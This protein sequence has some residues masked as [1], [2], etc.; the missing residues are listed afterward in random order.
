MAGPGAGNSLL[1][2]EEDGEILAVG[3]VTDA[4][5]ITLNY[6]SP[7]ARFRG[8]SRNMLAALEGRAAA[9][10]NAA[11]RLTSTET[12]RRFYQARGY[13]ETGPPAGGFGPRDI[14]CR[15]FSSFEII[16]FSR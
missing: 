4:G 13:S 1:V 14:R 8:V 16:D 9:R 3:S 2:A 5:E 7:D 6:V 11:C 10:G 15:G 12:A